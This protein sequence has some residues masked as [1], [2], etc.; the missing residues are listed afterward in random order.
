MA[1]SD[2]K[3]ISRRD[4][5]VGAL[6][7]AAG[8]L[9]A[10]KPET[11]AAATGSP[12]TA[13]GLVASGAPTIVWL[14]TTGDIGGQFLSGATLTSKTTPTAPTFGVVGETF[15]HAAAYSAGV[16]GY[17][18]SDLHFGVVADHRLPTGVALDVLGRARFARSGHDTIAKG[19]SVKSVYVGSGINS[20]SLIHVTLNG[21]GGTGVT[22]KYAAM[23]NATTFKVCLTKACTSSVRF[24]WM[25]TD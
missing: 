23:T 4:A 12:L 20:S 15:S 25:I 5:I 17:A 19:K 10:S 18:Y 7:L 24:T 16:R 9:I 8:T 11:V 1:D 21:N 3:V 2:P 13:G 6:A 22:L 14:T